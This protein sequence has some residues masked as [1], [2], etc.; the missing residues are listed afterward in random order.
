[1]DQMVFVTRL[2]STA[3]P[4]QNAADIVQQKDEFEAFIQKDKYLSKIRGQFAERNGSR[5][6]FTNIVDL[7]VQQDFNV[8]IKGNNHTFSIRLD[9]A[10]FTNL[11]NKDWGKQYFLTNDQFQLVNFQ[12]FVQTPA[13]NTPTYRF[14]TPA[15]GKVGTISDGVNVWNSSR[16][17]G[18]LTFRYSF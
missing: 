18:Q 4:A 2:S 3:T 7:N 16:W 5:L 17:N 12:G 8:K 1:M 10:N 9:I 14:F 15:N 6:P 13:A 11:L